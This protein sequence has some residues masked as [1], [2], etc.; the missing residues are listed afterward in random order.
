MLTTPTL[1]AAVFSLFHAQSRWQIA[2]AISVISASINA[3][4]VCFS[5]EAPKNLQEDRTTPLP[6]NALV[7][8]L[9]EMSI[10]IVT[11][12]PIFVRTVREQN[13]LAIQRGYRVAPEDSGMIIPK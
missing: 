2:V 3:L 4:L 10:S 9:G 8:G 1:I 5:F 13:S 6:W 7:S 12:Y 11:V